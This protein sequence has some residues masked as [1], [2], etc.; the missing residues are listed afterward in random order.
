MSR[1]WAVIGSNCFTGSHIVDALLDDPEN[2]VV[3]VSRSP[4]CPPLFRPYARHQSPRFTFHRIDSVRQFD[5]LTSLLD[6]VRPAVVVNV[7]ALSEVGLSNERPVEY[8]DINTNAV[9]R[10]CHHL[11]RCEYLERYVHVSS[12][13]IFGSCNRPVAEEAPFRPSTPYAVSKAAAD[14]FINVLIR[15]FGFPATIVRSTNVYGARQQLFKIIPR[16]IIYLRLRRTIELHGGGR[17]IKHF[18]HI[19]DVVRGILQAVERGGAG[20][21]HFTSDNDATVADVVARVCRLMDRRFEDATSPVAER[22]GQDARYWLDASMA[23][24]ELGWCEQ[25]TFDDGV[26]ETIEWID[27]YWDDVR[28]LPLTYVHNV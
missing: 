23:R 18:V 27:R 1:C 17:A 8:F 10:L 12:A 2:E 6:R 4:E 26:R 25:E 21:Y 19:R 20:T 22:Q 9:V 7:A 28:R 11:R 14:M 16:T 13:E 15:N 24:R 3:G 5:A